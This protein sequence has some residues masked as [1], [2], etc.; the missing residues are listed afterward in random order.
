MCGV[1]VWVCKY[2]HMY[3]YMYIEYMMGCIHTYIYTL[4]DCITSAMTAI[5]TTL[6]LQHTATH[7]NALQHTLRHTATHYNTLQQTA[8]LNPLQHTAAHCNTLQHTRSYC[9][10]WTVTGH[11]GKRLHLHSA[12]A[13]Q[14]GHLRMPNIARARN[15]QQPFVR[16]NIAQRQRSLPRKH[17]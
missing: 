17:T 9:V 7:Y 1:C 14:T 2:V 13:I 8:S 10:T 15:L 12:D 16:L 11:T 6:T 3:I 4:E 5:C